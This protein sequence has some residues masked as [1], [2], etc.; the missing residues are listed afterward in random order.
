M[1]TGE[2]ASKSKHTSGS[3]GIKESDFD[4]INLYTLKN[5]AGTE[6]KITNYGAAVTSIRVADRLGKYADIA[7]GYNSVESYMNADENPYFGATIGRYGN[8]I[9]KGVFELE[10][11]R[12]SLSINDGP[13]HLH[14]GVKGFDKVVWNANLIQGD[15]FTGLELSYLSKD[16]EEGYPGNLKCKV[17]YK[18]T[19]NNELV[20]EYTATTDKATP[21]NLTNHTY[22]NLAG[23]GNGTI[24]DHILMINAD[25]Y[26]PVDQTIIPT[27]A[28][29]PVKGTPF[30]F[31]S[32]KRIGLDLNRE[33]PQLRYGHGYDHNFVLSTGDKPGQMTLAATVYEPQSGRYM[34]VFT[35]EP[36]LQFYSGNFL[37]GRLT[38][39][40]G[41]PYIRNG[42]FCLETQHFPDSPNQVSFPSTILHPGETYSTKSMY[43]FSVKD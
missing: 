22:F 20:I 13:N 19:D 40:G 29:V 35:E 33:H 34:E 10:G 9:A 23:E 42:A 37:N 27:G 26:T 3:G 14:G 4:N 30:D 41:K 12:Y 25:R 38:G 36:G 28:I 18:L 24:L 39:K 21:V 7:L 15:G 16:G 8:R 11:K 2:E 31:T 5:E 6:I 32:E 17:V 43:R 1:I